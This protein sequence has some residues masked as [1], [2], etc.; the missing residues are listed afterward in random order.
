MELRQKFFCSFGI[1]FKVP[2]VVVWNLGVDVHLEFGIGVDM[3]A[4]KP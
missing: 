2:S 3:S 1:S 4:M